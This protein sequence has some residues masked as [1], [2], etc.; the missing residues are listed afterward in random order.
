MKVQNGEDVLLEVQPESRLLVIWFFG[1]CFSVGVVAF[2]AGFALSTIL[3][4]VYEVVAETELFAVESN[5]DGWSVLVNAIIAIAA[6]LCSRAIVLIYCVYLRRTYV[7]T[8]TNRRCIFRGGILR[9]V[10]HSVPFH[11]VTD[12]EMSQ[13]IIERILGISSLGIFTPGTGSMGSSCKGRRPEIAFIGLKDNETPAEII[14]DIL[15][16]YKATGQ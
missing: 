1:R 3:S 13:N 14:N 9:R 16:N 10:E 2:A 4:M 5:F 12:V 6:A 7:Y 8:I 11:K 15:S